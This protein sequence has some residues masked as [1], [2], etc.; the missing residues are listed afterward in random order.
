MGEDA[1]GAAAD[2]VC[3]G[4]AVPRAGVVGLVSEHA[5]M[6]KMRASSRTSGV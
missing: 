4:G 1:D 5:P 2:V 3:V 6:R